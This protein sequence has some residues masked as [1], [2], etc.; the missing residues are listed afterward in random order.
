MRSWTYEALLERTKSEILRD[1]E[2]GRVPP[3]VR[4]FGE[5]HCYVDANT[6]GGTC[7]D[8]APEPEDLIAV[9]NRVQNTVHAWLASGRREIDMRS[10]E[11]RHLHEVV[12]V[13]R[14]CEIGA[15]GERA[16][17]VELAGG[18]PPYEHVYMTLLFPDRSPP[19][20]LVRTGADYLYLRSVRA[21][22]F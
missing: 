14:D 4:S 11:K 10:N 17:V 16:V 13:T 9:V 21:A 19:E 5:L 12:E 8:D 2:S 3:T 15:K 20:R 6:Y 22:R 7:D 18:T 1:I